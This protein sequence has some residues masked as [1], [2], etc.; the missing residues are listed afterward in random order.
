MKYILLFLLMIPVLCKAQFKEASPYML[1]GGIALTVGAAL[2][3]NE[4]RWDASTSSYKA[5]GLFEQGA[6]SMAFG[7]GLAVTFTGVI[8]SLTGNPYR[9]YRKY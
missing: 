7:C 2:T 6:K 1:G 5:K 8:S 3:P 9:G 4:T